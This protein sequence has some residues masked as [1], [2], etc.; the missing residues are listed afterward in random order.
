MWRDSRHG[1]GAARTA[2][3]PRRARRQVRVLRVRHREAEE[4]GAALVELALVAPV[5]ALFLFGIADFGLIFSGYYVMRNGVQAAARAASVGDYSYSGN[6][7][8][9]PSSQTAQMVCNVASLIGQ[10]LG[11]SAGSLAIGVCFVTPGSSASGCA[12]QSGTGT[13][14]SQDVEICAQASLKSTTGVTSPFL[15]GR[16]I[17]TTSRTL[18]E[19][20]VPSGST[21]FGAFNASSA[22]VSY[23]GVAITGMN[24]S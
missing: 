11:T 5:L 17:S 13:S 14:L 10:P 9:G 6:C 3:T 2:N 24:C 18:I 19:Q 16:T 4:S 15:T 8:G 21:G 7:S 23:N 22:S 12:S 1:T 20:P